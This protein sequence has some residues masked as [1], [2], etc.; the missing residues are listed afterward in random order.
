M[1]TSVRFSSLLFVLLPG[2][3]A[4]VAARGL[5][6]KVPVVDLNP[7]ACVQRVDVHRLAIRSVPIV[8]NSGSEIA[9]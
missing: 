8:S 6:E 7:S 2:S 1:F 4:F 5:G 3:S 9:N